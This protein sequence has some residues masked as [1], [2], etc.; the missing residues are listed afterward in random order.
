[1]P[2]FLFSKDLADLFE[3]FA[4]S[5]TLRTLIFASAAIETVVEGLSA[6]A[7]IIAHHILCVI[8]E[9]VYVVVRPHLEDAGNVYFSRAGLA[10]L[11]ACA[12][13]LGELLDLFH[14]NAE[15]FPFFLGESGVV[16]SDPDIFL[17][18]V[19]I[20]HTGE[21]A[22]KVGI[23]E[24]ELERKLVGGDGRLAGKLCIK[25]GGSC[26]AA[27][28]DRTHSNGAE[29]LFINV[30]DHFLVCAVE[31]IILT[32]HGFHLNAHGFRSVNDVL[33]R[34]GMIVKGEGDVSDETLFLCLRGCFK[35][36]FGDDL[37]IEGAAV[38]APE[39]IEINVVGSET[40][41]TAF[42]MCT[43]SVGSHALIHRTLGGQK[44]LIAEIF[45]C[46]TESSLAVGI[47]VVGSGVEIVHAV[48]IGVSDHFVYLILINEI[49]PALFIFG[50]THTAEAERG[51]LFAGL[52]KITVIHKYILFSAFNS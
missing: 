47:A 17:Y 25:V 34:R 19:K 9:T 44:Y 5:E 21:S 24:A 22:V 11:A 13:K 16:G 31:K 35:K 8:L 36:S 4:D 40:G 33:D 18:H 38:D 10:V 6:M 32:E 39:M 48:F 29:T 50:K 28:A 41:Q 14:S 20:L 3:I 23:A 1:M 51:D 30:F 12:V 43:V 46:V 7:D 27:A 26:K 45:N 15:L 37:G 49:V 42:E 2:L 52:S